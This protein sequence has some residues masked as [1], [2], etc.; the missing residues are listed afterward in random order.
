MCLSLLF[1]CFFSNF[2]PYSKRMEILLYSVLFGSE[3]NNQLIYAHSI[4]QLSS[5][6][7]RR[8]EA[9]ISG[10]YESLLAKLQVDLLR[11]L[12]VI[13]QISVLPSDLYQNPSGPRNREVAV[14]LPRH[15]PGQ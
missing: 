1:P 11:A 12:T 8:Q 9:E 5:L 13:L 15:S 2:I 10:F 4:Q 3:V 6:S 14:N 7:L